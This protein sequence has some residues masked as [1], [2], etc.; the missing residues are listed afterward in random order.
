MLAF[1]RHWRVQA[2][3]PA[4]ERGPGIP[5]DG[6]SEGKMAR[7]GD[8]KSKLTKGQYRSVA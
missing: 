1:A 7:V 3:T 2:R 5:A 4:R 6:L 8:V